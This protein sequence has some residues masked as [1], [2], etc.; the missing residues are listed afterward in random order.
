MLN[1]QRS[2]DGEDG[3]GGGDYAQE[4]L[5]EIAAQ[6]RAIRCPLHGTPP[7]VIMSDGG[8]TFETCC[9]DLDNAIDDAFPEPENAD[10]DEAEEV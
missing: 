2:S 3:F 7:T 10:E 6:A 1:E 8:I 9:E 4:I 5:E